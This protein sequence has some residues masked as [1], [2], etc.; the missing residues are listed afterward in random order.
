MSPASGV[1]T[2]QRAGIYRITFTGLFNSLKGHMVT[3]DIIKKSA[4]AIR[5]LGRSSAQ[6]TETGSLFGKLATLQFQMGY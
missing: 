3:A 5:F 1:F 4:G 2:V 6:T